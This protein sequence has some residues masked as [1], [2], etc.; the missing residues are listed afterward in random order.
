MRTIHGY[1]KVG[2]T[3]PL[4]RAWHHMKQRCFNAKTKTYNH[5]GGRGIDVCD[6]W[7]NDPKRFVEWGLKNGWRKG[8]Y[9][10]RVDNDGNYSPENCRF[11]DSKLNNH[12][13]RLLRS[14]N[15]S[16][17]RGV[18]YDKE[19]NK[20]RSCITIN[21]KGKQLGRFNSPRLAA[22]RYDVEAYLNGDNRPR[23]III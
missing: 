6:E 21:G 17:Y 1:N 14:N 4:Y 16:G 19:N 13:Q 3:H 7:I 12:N 23:N 11:V 2:K 22:L 5:Y 9:L 8:L 20:W 18:T 15:S 10:D